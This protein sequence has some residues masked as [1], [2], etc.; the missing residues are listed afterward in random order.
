MRNQRGRA[1]AATGPSTNRATG[2]IL[3][4]SNRATG[5]VHRMGPVSAAATG[6]G[7]MGMLARVGNVTG[8]GLIGC[9]TRSLPT[10]LPAAVPE[11]PALLVPFPSASGYDCVSQRVRHGGRSGGG[12][13]ERESREGGRAARRGRGTERQDEEEGEG[14]QEGV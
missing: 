8:C 1:Q 10:G 13:R 9:G 2:P 7:L 14:E 5:P 12:E 11:G 4:S 3:C 6:G